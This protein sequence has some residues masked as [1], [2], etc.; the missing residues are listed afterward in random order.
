MIEKELEELKAEAK[1]EVTFDE[2]S[3][4]ELVVGKV[5]SAEPVP[6]SNK[7]LVMRVD[8]GGSERQIVSGIAKSATPEEMIGKHVIVVANLKKAKLMGLESEGMI[9]CGDLSGGGLHIPSLDALE[10]G[11]RLC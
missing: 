11:T 2:F 5:L 6:K 7:L 10:P 1:P 8:L 9:L 3:K 4:V